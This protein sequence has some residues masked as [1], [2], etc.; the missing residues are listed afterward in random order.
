LASDQ[1][2][3]PWSYFINICSPVRGFSGYDL[4]QNKYPNAKGYQKSQDESEC[5]P[6]TGSGS[7]D[8]KLSFIDSNN[9]GKGVVLAYDAF[10]Y[11]GYTRT[12]MITALCDYHVENATVVFEKEDYE[13]ASS[14]YY[15]QMTT[16]H[17]CPM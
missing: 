6:M 15:F 9:P 8:V 12:V 16:K 13:V 5:F 11:N 4:C 17:A 1:G 10:E 3:N 14:K 7:D 2:H